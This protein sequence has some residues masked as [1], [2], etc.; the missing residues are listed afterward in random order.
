MKYSTATVTTT[1]G[2]RLKVWRDADA[3]SAGMEVPVPV[4][5]ED[6]MKMMQMVEENTVVVEEAD[7]ANVNQVVE[8]NVEEPTLHVPLVTRIRQYHFKKLFG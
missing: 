5:T 8:T 4:N 1:L 3:D 6:S 7:E 2:E